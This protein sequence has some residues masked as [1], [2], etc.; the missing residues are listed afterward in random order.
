YGM[1]KSYREYQRHTRPIKRLA[2][3]LIVSFFLFGIIGGLAIFLMVLYGPSFWV[4]EA[5]SVTASYLLLSNSA[6]GLLEK[7]EVRHRARRKPVP[8]CPL[9]VAGIVGSRRDALTLLKA[10]KSYLGTPLMIIARE[11]PDQWRRSTGLSPEE[12]VWLTRVEHPQAISPSNLHV[13]AERIVEFLRTSED[14]VVYIEGIEYMLFYS[15]F[16]AVAKFLFSIRDTAMIYGG[17]VLVL[18]NDKTLRPE[19]MAILKR[20]FEEVRVSELLERIIGPTLFG[21]VVKGRKGHAGAEGSEEGS[22]AGEEKAEEARPLR[23]EE[24]AKERK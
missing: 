20:E 16:R 15:D 10:L 19:Y 9:P 11:H 2:A 13:L 22:G 14:G 18:A 23:G 21:V 24:A 8:L 17:H 5:V 7:V 12:Y 3:T 1:M 4:L 6:L